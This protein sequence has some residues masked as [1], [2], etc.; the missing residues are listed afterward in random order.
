MSLSTA[1]QV[2][3]KKFL[4]VGG[5]PFEVRHSPPPVPDMA[6]MTGEDFDR[7]LERGWTSMETGNVIDA[8]QA[9]KELQRVLQRQ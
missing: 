5:F 3:L 8:K 1:I 9:R 6:T 4:L 7:E 2:F